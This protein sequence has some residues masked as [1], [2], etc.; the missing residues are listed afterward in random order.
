MSPL[1]MDLSTVI[2]PR[3]VGDPLAFYTV[4]A[5]IIPVLFL[6]LVYQAKYFQPEEKPYSLLSLF[7][8]YLA[9][10]TM[11]VAAAG[12]VAALHT[13]ET[14]HPTLGAQ[15]GVSIALIIFGTA[16]L[17]EPVLSVIGRWPDLPGE[18]WHTKSRTIMA[19]WLG[20]VWFFAI[21]GI[22]SVLRV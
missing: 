2:P 5:T 7:Q 12:E 17:S 6:A 13:L 4:A 9:L 22:L 18:R 19:L 15:Q 11:V 1:W 21:L 3:K 8:V 14:Q 10:G 16:L 20:I